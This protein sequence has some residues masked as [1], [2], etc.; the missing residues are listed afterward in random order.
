MGIYAGNKKS[1][2]PLIKDKSSICRYL[3]WTSLVLALK[4]PSPGFSLQSWANWTVPMVKL[5]K[6]DTKL[7]SI[8]D[9]TSMI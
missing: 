5:W 7:A 2:C 3:S 9:R 8:I 4:I 6:L 1:P